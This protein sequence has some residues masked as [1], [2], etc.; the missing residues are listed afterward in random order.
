[1]WPGLVVSRRDS[2]GDDDDDD[3]VVSP[4]QSPALE[5]VPRSRRAKIP[6]NGFIT[7]HGACAGTRLPDT[8]WSSLSQLGAT[9]I[10]VFTGCYCTSIP[11]LPSCDSVR[12]ATATSDQFGHHV[13]HVH[14][15]VRDP[16]TPV[17]SRTPSPA[18]VCLHCLVPKIITTT[19]PVVDVRRAQ[20][21]AGPPP[22]RASPA[23]HLP[24]IRD[25]FNRSHPSTHYWRIPHDRVAAVRRPLRG[26]PLSRSAATD[27][28]RARNG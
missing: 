24:Q 5:V 17:P 18:A 1:M 19:T 2:R 7:R 6:C 25:P 28:A 14:V 27:P 26:R 23:G 11:I 22:P 21:C 8:H 15:R 12:V 13:Y 9:P 10:A 16:H 4:S 20:P 3:P